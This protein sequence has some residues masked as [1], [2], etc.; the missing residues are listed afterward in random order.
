MKKVC[1]TALLCLSAYALQAQQTIR[2]KI[3]DKDT[4]VPLEGV[5]VLL[6]A[7]DPPVGTITDEKGRFVFEELPLGTYYLRF[8]YLGFESKEVEDIQLRPSKEAYLAIELSEAI[9][10]VATV[11]VKAKQDNNAPLNELSTLSAQSFKMADLQRQPATFGDPAR[12]ALSFP[13]VSLGEDD[14]L[15][16]VIVRGNS[17]RAILWRLEGIEIPNPNH[18][19][20]RGSAGGG[21]S[22]L[23]PN[24]MGTSDFFSGA[25]PGEFGNAL[26]GVF[27]IRMRNGNSAK[28]E[29]ALQVGLLGVE[30][31]TEGPLGIL[32]DDS[33][34]LQY[35]YST[36]GI[37]KDLGVTPTDGTVPDFQDLSF[38]VY[39]PTSSFGTFSLFGLGGTFIEQ[40]TE[41]V[42]GAF[43]QFKDKGRMGIAGLS[44]LLFLSKQTYLKTI[45]ASTYSSLIYQEKIGEVAADLPLRYD[46]DF[47]DR[48]NR[49]SLLLNHKINARH[50]LRLGFI[51]SYLNFNL[52]ITEEERELVTQNGNISPI[53]TGQWQTLLQT[54]GQTSTQQVYGQWKFQINPQITLNT[55]L[56]YFRLQLAGQG[57]LEPRL[58]L[59]WQFNP[60]E[61]LSIGAGLHSRM[62]A[63]PTYFANKEIA[64]GEFGEP[65]QTLP[66]QT[67]THLVLGYENQLNAH[68]R[69]KME[70]Y[71]QQLD[72]L[73]VGQDQ[74][75]NFA[76]LNENYF[77]VFF[78][79]GILEGT[80]EGRNTGIDISLNREYHDQ[81]YWLLNTSL[82]QSQYRLKNGE[83]YSTRF[84]SQFTIT[85]LGGKDFSWGTNKQHAIGLNIKLL[86]RGG[87]RYTPLDREAS[88]AEQRPVFS[89]QPYTGQ[90]PTYWRIDTGLSY[91]LFTS[92][93]VHLFR[94]NIQNVTNQLNVFQRRAAFNPNLSDPIRIVDE[95][96]L[97]TL[98]ILSYRLEF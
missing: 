77:D 49:L 3:V 72:K 8:Q 66:L 9:T 60:R 94:L 34:L 79:P 14:I 38:K 12:L 43:S 68:L 48:I 11:E 78:K 10:T 51:S 92:K 88:L 84:D 93:M 71:H 54:K 17:P 23:S 15:N 61:K 91:R 19:S 33:Y 4:Q 22:M 67:A 16:E 59:K 37:L 40:E 53:W 81:Y 98:P 21:I 97:S 13:G 50:L 47:T 42:S 52:K 89:T 5:N 30:A 31:A 75:S 1:F 35:R 18:F 95:Y 32:V 39:L 83:W 85:A 24:A 26:S 36:L 57:S 56:H 87:N 63:L 7:T 73:A 90:L 96:Q 46:E 86:L 41:G 69:L 29:T 70:V 20:V 2:G 82:Y 58:G 55:G 74:Q 25:F 80:G 44:H 45:F 28:R 76:L 6:L 62:E 27:D 65:H 64:E